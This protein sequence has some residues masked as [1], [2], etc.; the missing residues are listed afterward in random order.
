MTAPD[1]R[2]W[3]SSVY[4]S[5]EEPDPRFTLANERTL[6]A[7][8][9]TALALVGAGVVVDAVDL[10]VSDTVQHVLGAILVILG[11]GAAVGAWFRWA[12]IER[13]MRHRRPLPGMPLAAGVILGLIVVGVV[14]LVALAA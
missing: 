11:G 8:I 1:H 12:Q 9:R 13:S 10:E 7:W 4:G 3:P 6:L 2:R 5:G 14:V